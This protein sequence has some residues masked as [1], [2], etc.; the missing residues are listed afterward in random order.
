MAVIEERRTKGGELSYR[1]KVRIKGRPSASRTFKRKTDAKK[2]AVKTEAAI[3]EGRH[4]GESHR[5]TLVEALD[6]YLRDDLPSLSS[7]E[8]RNRT[9][10]LAW[11]RAALGPYM[12][13]DLTPALIGE[14]RDKLGAPNDS[15]KR[16]APATVVRYLA[17]LSHVL[18]RAVEWG[19][20][21][22]NPA[23]AVTRPREP[24]GRV[25][26]LTD[27]ERE[28]LLAACAASDLAMLHP[29]VVLALATGAR[30]GELLSLRWP[31]VDL[32]RGRVVFHHTKNGDRR[33]A[34]LTGVPRAVLAEW[35][36]VRQLDDD[37]VFPRASFPHRIWDRA[38]REAGITDFRFHD[39][40]HSA[41]SYLAMNGASLLEIAE[42]LGH[43]TL[44][45]VR[46]Y[47]H[48]T[49]GHTTGVVSRMNDAI[50]GAAE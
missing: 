36:K 39:L 44:T 23:K 17:A 15:G 13:N 42:V 24:R 33:S 47:A 31:D 9:R 3:R 10:Q 49:D 45:M 2:W 43:K 12:L 41:A 29:M 14:N 48:L 21:R 11:W 5:H 1:V 37:R 38:L 50:F 19:W 27:E 30:R 6:R 18:S 34:P 22:D 20:I 7:S 4:F 40:R 32:E 28:A 8:Q 25:R 35:G 46:R 26:Y 16:R